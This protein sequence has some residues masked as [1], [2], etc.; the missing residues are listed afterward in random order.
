MKLLE[1]EQSMQNET[2]SS[3]PSDSPARIE[4]EGDKEE[5]KEATNNVQSSEDAQEE[6]SARRPTSPTP[7]EGGRSA[8]SSIT[9]VS[10][11]TRIHPRFAPTVGRE[12]EA[13]TVHRADGRTLVIDKNRIQ[14]IVNTEDRAITNALWTMLQTAM[15]PSSD[16]SGV[17]NASLPVWG[18]LL[19]NNV[20]MQFDYS[21]SIGT[22]DGKRVPTPGG[23]T[24]LGVFSADEGGFPHSID[25]THGHDEYRVYTSRS[26]IT[27]GELKR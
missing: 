22:G 6:A 19:L 27:A 10:E 5:D 1:R 21:V 24:D 23:V 14:K 9:S 3:S 8:S 15:R 20:S 11:D 2:S 12:L 17:S 25:S 16:T 18:K 13:L 7:T 26:L 4:E